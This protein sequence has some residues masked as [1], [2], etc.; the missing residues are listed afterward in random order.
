MN[1]KDSYEIKVFVNLLLS[2]KIIFDITNARIFLKMK[3]N[4][5]YYR[6]YSVIEKS[7]QNF[8]GL[9][10]EVTKLIQKRKFVKSL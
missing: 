1:S 6:S 10:L 4:M 7:L 5:Y 8:N 2:I 3:K 9:R